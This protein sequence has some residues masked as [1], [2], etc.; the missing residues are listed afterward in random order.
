MF[1]KKSELA[2]IK[3]ARA[4]YKNNDCSDTP[5][6]A[7]KNAI[8]IKCHTWTEAGC[9]VK[10]VLVGGVS[11]KLTQ[12]SCGGGGEC[13]DHTVSPAEEPK[14]RMGTHADSLLK[15]K[16]LFLIIGF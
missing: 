10:R 1:Y 8:P 13:P 9:M 4:K 3:R 6:E 16:Q 15:K 14:G 5:N 7:N 2:F 12:F 11:A